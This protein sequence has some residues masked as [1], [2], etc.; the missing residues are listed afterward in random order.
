MRVN[1]EYLV[2]CGYQIHLFWFPFL[3]INFTANMYTVLSFCVDTH[4]LTL[5]NKIAHIQ[6]LSVFLLDNRLAEGFV[7]FVLPL[8]VGVPVMV[9]RR[10][11]GSWWS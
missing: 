8:L 9:A 7:H 2:I 1:F 10:S 5:Y 4:T 11:S 6:A 3:T